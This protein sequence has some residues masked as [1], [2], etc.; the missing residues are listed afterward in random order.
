MFTSPNSRGK[1]SKDLSFLKYNV[2][3]YEWQIFEASTSTTDGGRNMR[4]ARFM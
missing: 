1:G 4:P 3:E 2:C